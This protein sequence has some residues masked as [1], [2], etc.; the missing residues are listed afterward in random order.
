M[1]ERSDLEKRFTVLLKAAV[2]RLDDEMRNLVTLLARLD[3]KKPIMGENLRVLSGVRDDLQ[4]KAFL[5]DGILRSS[6]SAKEKE[7]SP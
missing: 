2:E 5:L 1:T 7:V 6:E 3:P 4:L